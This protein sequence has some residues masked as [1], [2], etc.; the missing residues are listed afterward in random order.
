MKTST[1]SKTS[2]SRMIFSLMPDVCIL[3]CARSPTHS[4]YFHILNSQYMVDFIYVYA[5]PPPLTLFFQS[6]HQP[7]SSSFRWWMRPQ[8]SWNGP[9]LI[10]WEEEVT[11]ATVWSVS[12]VRLG[13]TATLVVEPFLGI[14]ASLSLRL[15]TV[16]WEC[17]QTRGLWDPKLLI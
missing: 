7:H 6:H 1:P 3:G 2:H 4:I 15:S 17:S 13:A 5:L 14:A 11:Q 12:S 8:W 16:G 9:P 10:V